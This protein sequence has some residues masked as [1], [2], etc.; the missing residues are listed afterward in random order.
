M[1][2]HSSTVPGTWEKL[3][4]VQASRHP[5][6][7]WLRMEPALELEEHRGSQ[8]RRV[9]WPGLSVQCCALRDAVPWSGTSA[10][11]PDWHGPSAP[12]KYQQKGGRLSQNWNPDSLGLL[13]GEVSG[14]PGAGR[15]SRAGANSGPTLRELGEDKGI[16]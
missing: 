9:P 5:E 8:G 13:G 12:P 14:R 3:G 4:N 7:G 16:E 2:K 1:S 15:I 6:P 11:L 10:P